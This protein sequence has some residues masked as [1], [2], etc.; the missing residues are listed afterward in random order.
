MIHPYLFAAL[1]NERH[2]ELLAQADRDRLARQARAHGSPTSRPRRRRLA[3]WL[4]SEL[5]KGQLQSASAAGEAQP[6]LVTWAAEQCA[7]PP[8]AGRRVSF[9]DGSTVLV[10]PVEGD[11]AHLLIDGFS[12]LS[13]ASRESRFLYRKQSLS[14]AEVRYLT[15][16]DHH[17]HEALGAVAESDGRGV[18]VARFIRDPHDRCSAELGVAVV[19]DWHRRGLATELVGQLVGRAL[20]EGIHQFTALIA[21]DNI[22]PLG[23]LRKLELDVELT[24]Y[25]DGARLYTI[26]LV[27][28]MSV[29]AR[30]ST[31]SC[32]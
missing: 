2:K 9:A 18:G 31:A 32:S 3:S 6:S 21:V 15:E 11:D 5:A 29:D 12:R 22:A 1:A 30:R 8:S 23:L 27:K 26:D 13:P 7:Q 4:R 20:E 16:I 17:D 25:G 28:A 10:R 19:D 14:A 24:A